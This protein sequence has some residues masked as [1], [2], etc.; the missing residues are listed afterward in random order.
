MAHARNEQR[1]RLWLWMGFLLA[2]LS[3]GMFAEPAT[4]RNTR[5]LL[6][7][8]DAKKD[9]RYAEN[10]PNDDVAFYFADQGHPAVQ[11]TYEEAVTNRKGNSFG[12]SDEDACQFTMIS[13]LKQLNQRAHELG[14]DAVINIV[15]YYRKVTFS[16]QTEYECHAGAFVAG[17][18]LKGTI[19]KLAK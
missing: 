10:V 16:S 11:T 2:A 9:P 5:Y 14:G 8:E 7:I 3:S 12:R 18:T 17:V 1:K 6:K 19:V 13:A 15:S 4:A